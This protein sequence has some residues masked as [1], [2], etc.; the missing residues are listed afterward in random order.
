M[1]LMSV[2]TH[3]METTLVFLVF[4][5]TVEGSELYTLSYIGHTYELQACMHG[6]LV[7][8]QYHMIKFPHI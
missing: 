5:V 2:L 1:Q 3:S 4:I 8:N 7:I 6:V